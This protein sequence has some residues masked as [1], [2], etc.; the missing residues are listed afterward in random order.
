MKNIV[1]ILPASGNPSGIAIIK[2]VT[3]IIKKLTKSYK[4][5]IS[6]YLVP[7]AKATIRFVSK[8]VKVQIAPT[9]PIFPISFATP[10]NFIYNG[11]GSS[12]CYNC[13][14]NFPYLVL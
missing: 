4:I 8:A 6:N 13:N 7:L 12:F 3:P 5:F 11:V 9:N 2:I 1:Y 10:S 14:F